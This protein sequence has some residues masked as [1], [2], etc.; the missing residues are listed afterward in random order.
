VINA[1][2]PFILSSSASVPRP[3]PRL[4]PAAQFQQHVSDTRPTPRLDIIRQT[5]HRRQ[6]HRMPSHGMVLVR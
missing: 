5:L 6:R 3:V 1:L 4:V 2:P